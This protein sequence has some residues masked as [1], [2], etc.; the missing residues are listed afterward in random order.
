MWGEGR[1]GAVFSLPPCLGAGP[2]LCSALCSGPILEP[3]NHSALMW[4]FLD[5]ELMSSVNSGGPCGA[6]KRLHV[7]PW[8]VQARGG[9]Q[10]LG[11]LPGGYCQSWFG[12]GSGKN[13]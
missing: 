7:V 3:Q 8:L 6:V 5:I 11:S 1:A 13:K 12:T 10:R 9:A 4:Y 2:R